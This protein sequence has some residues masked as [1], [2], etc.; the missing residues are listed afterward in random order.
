[1]VTL[2]SKVDYAHGLRWAVLFNALTK[3]ISLV[4]ALLIARKLGPEV[5]SSYFV[6]LAIFS[7]ADIFREAGLST[8]FLNDRE[9]TPERESNY[10]FAA[11]LSGLIPAGVITVCSGLIPRYFS[12]P[13]L[14]QG[15]LYTGLLLVLNGLATVPVAKLFHQNRFKIAGLVESSAF[16][17]S[18]AVAL[19]LIYSGFGFSALMIQLVICALI[20]LIGNY[21]LAGIRFRVAP[22]RAIR[23]VLRK[24]FVIMSGN[25]FFL[26]YLQIDQLIVAKLFGPVLS[27]NYG[28]GKQLTAKQGDFV[29]VPLMRTIQVAIGHRAGEVERIRQALG[30]ALIAFTIVILPMFACVAILAQPLVIALFSVKYSA[31]VAFVPVFCAYT[32]MKVFGGL[33]GNI[34]VAMDR[35]EVIVKCWLIGV[36]AVGAYFVLRYQSVS[37]LEVAWVFTGGMALVNFMILAVG[38]SLVGYYRRASVRIAQGIL[39]STMIAAAS[40]GLLALG[41]DAWGTVIISIP[42]LPVL[43]GLILGTIFARH[44]L[45]FF[46]RSRTREFW[47]AL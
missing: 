21:R 10:L 6:I 28:I 15:A 17:I 35:S 5:M 39:A 38:V 12:D 16:L 7:F 25:L 36:I 40:F 9:L 3:S 13:N 22:V 32:M 1:M 46:S 30:K 4:A 26:S 43:Y 24:G 8:A 14:F 47:E 19:V 41:L 31:A 20:T 37:A 34:V 11:F 44:P 42:T 45:H 29:G 23:G 27:G 2:M 33:P 18:Y